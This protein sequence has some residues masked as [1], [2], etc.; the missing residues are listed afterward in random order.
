MAEAK[1]NTF[2]GAK[3]A[4][5]KSVKAMNKKL[6]A[7]PVVDPRSQYSN[8]LISRKPNKQPMNNKSTQPDSYVQNSILQLRTIRN[9]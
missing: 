5:G 2:G 6:N 1:V 8:S 3:K 9:T 4:M 7:K